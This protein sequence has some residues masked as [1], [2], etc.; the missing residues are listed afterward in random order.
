MIDSNSNRLLQFLPTSHT[1]K[2]NIYQLILGVILLISYLIST[3]Y[4]IEKLGIIIIIVIYSISIVILKFNKKN[5]TLSLTWIILFALAFRLIAL[6]NGIISNNLMPF[7]YQSN[8]EWLGIFINFAHK[9]LKPF[10]PLIQL[11][12]LLLEGILVY[13]TIIIL[14]NRKIEKSILL[15]YLWNP[16]LIINLYNVP[17]LS[18]VW[19]IVILLCS[20]ILYTNKKT[21]TSIM[22]GL[23]VSLHIFSFLLIPL[24]LR[25]LKYFIIISFVILTGLFIAG[26]FDSLVVQVL[27]S[28]WIQNV[29]YFI[30]LDS[31]I[32]DFFIILIS[33]LI[34]LIIVWGTLS[35]KEFLEKIF[36]VF[37]L[38]ILVYP[39]FYKEVYILMILLGT[40]Y[41]NMSLI[42]LSLYLLLMPIF[43][44][45]NLTFISDYNLYF[46][47]I[48][49]Y[50]ISLPIIKEKIKNYFTR[51]TF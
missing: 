46:Q 21:Y 13:L 5:V 14:R 40:I 10:S 27:G 43:L 23:S 34:L 20:I 16:F 33:S 8:S 25:K 19:I 51:K 45:Y 6:Y 36:W 37:Y 35:Q 31:K 29:F 1:N 9:Y 39:G 12:T 44:S 48:L 50:L 26:L 3:F 18:I 49:L 15:I 42:V 30:K 22:L 11:I 32:T 7:T 41:R 4:S 24:G 47:Y 28:E 38:I 2:F 17:S